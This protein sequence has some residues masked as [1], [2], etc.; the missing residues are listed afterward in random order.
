MNNTYI[1]TLILLIFLQGNLRGAPFPIQ[2]SIS[3]H[4]IV[5]EIPC[6]DKDFA[7]II[8][9]NLSTYIYK[10]ESEYYKDYQRSYFAVT[11]PKAGWDAMRHYEILAN[12]CIPYFLHLEKCDPNVMHFLPKE[13]LFEALNLDGV[14][15]L[16]IDH[17]K[18][19]KKKYYE[20][21]EKLIAHTRKHLTTKNMA[22]YLLKKVNYHG[23]G[24]VLFLT[25]TAAPD[26]LPD[27]ILAGLK[28][29]LQERII[30][31]P[32]IDYIYKTYTKNIQDLYGKG[33]TYSKIIDDIDINRND[34]EQRI[35]NKEFDIIIYGS[36]HRGLPYIDLVTKIYSPEE[37]IYLCGEDCHY[38]PYTHLPNFF[39]REVNTYQ[40]Y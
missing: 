33:M 32:K 22:Q 17:T 40:P 7:S 14:S 3:E 11:C 1:Y 4:K 21:L 35:L 25:S 20:L 39:L 13:L 26:Y 29:L 8:P 34:I 6:K 19:D 36:I 37:I 28:E 9:G 23:T 38:C 15:Y 30:D 24:N 5:Q 16:N 27:S 18:F 12:G 10:I 31:V 2:F